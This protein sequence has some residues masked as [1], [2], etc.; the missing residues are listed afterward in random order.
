MNKTQILLLL[1][2]QLK[3]NLTMLVLTLARLV[4]S[5]TYNTEHAK[6]NMILGPIRI[7]IKST[8]LKGQGK[9]ERDLKKKINHYQ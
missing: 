2:A 5:S 9:I 6:R 8:V 7:P 4:Y 1:L 3:S